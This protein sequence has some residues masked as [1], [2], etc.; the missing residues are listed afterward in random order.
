LRACSALVI[1]ARMEAGR[2]AR[3]ELIGAAALFST[4]GAA[5]KACSLGG[6]QI[7]GLRSFVAVFAFLVLVRASRRLPRPR[8]WLVGAAYAACLV[9][10]VVSNKLTTAAD[11]IFLQSASPVYMLLLAPLLLGERIRGRDLTFMVV[12]ACGIGAFFLD[13]L[14]GSSAA[15]AQATAPNVWLGRL[16]ALG[17]GVA[18]AFT[19]LGLRWLGAN[20]SPSESGAASAVLAGNVLAALACLV[21]AGPHVELGARDLAIVLW[22]GVFQIALAYKLVTQAVT[23]VPAFEASVLLLVEPVFNPLW[24]WLVHGERPTF[25]ALVGGAIILAATLVKT[26]LDARA[27]AAP[28]LTDR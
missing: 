3:W 1:V 24:A 12:I 16:V 9:A 4:G 23:H 5:I 15:P 27:R 25:W 19:M 8:E 22:L 11:A 17:S 18:W 21:V 26:W 2:R 13:Q 6:W 14:D 20:K 10:F 7:A 28:A